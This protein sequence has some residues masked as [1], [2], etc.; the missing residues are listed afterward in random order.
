MSDSEKKEN[1]GK[2][3]AKAS[4]QPAK[5]KHRPAMI[6]GIVVAV[7]VVV[8]VGFSVWHSQPSFCNA[9][10]HN[11]M[12]PYVETYEATPGQPA[13]D[14]WGND[15]S[16]A[17][18]M[19]APVHAQA[20]KTCLDCH[21]P[22]LNEQITEGEQWVSGSY[23]SPLSERTTQQ[24][25]VPRGIENSDEFCTNDTCHNFSHDDLIKKTAWM[26]PIN[27]HLNQHGQQKCSTC[28]KAHRASVMYCTQCH[29][30][31]VVP[32]GWVS[33]SESQALDQPSY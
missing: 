12:D 7:V 29:T 1:A 15:V 14:K 28:H 11:P 8:G 17:S 10:C 13:T 21:E 16:N 25:L 3:E 20:G 6:V 30:E 27:P 31:A 4:E 9:I 22:T 23:N 19:L 24:L 2:A 18:A 33:Y 26:G 32:D 5:K